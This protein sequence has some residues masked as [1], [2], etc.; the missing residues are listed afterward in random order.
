M[1]VLDFMKTMQWLA[2]AGH[3]LGGLAVLL[4]TV[5]FT[6]SWWWIGGVEALLVV[7]IVAK[8]GWIDLAYESGETPTSSAEDAAGY[9]LGNAVAWGLVALAHAVGSW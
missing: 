3:F 9:V 7:Y 5:L 2:N 6:H 8:E 1:A 4:V